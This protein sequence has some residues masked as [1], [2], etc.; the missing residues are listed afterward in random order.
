MSPIQTS[1]DVHANFAFEWQPLIGV[2]TLTWTPNT[3]KHDHFP[4]DKFFHILNI[5]E[6]HGS[7][8]YM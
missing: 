8:V 4:L 7:Y 5:Y 2:N 3:Q 1:F 6:L